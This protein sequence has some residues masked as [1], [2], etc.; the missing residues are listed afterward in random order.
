MTEFGGFG[1]LATAGPMRLGG[2]AFDML[3]ALIEA[4][5]AV[6]SKDA[7]LGRAQQGRIVDQNPQPG[8]RFR[9]DRADRN[10]RIRRGSVDAGAGS[11]P[12]CTG[13][14]RSH[15]LSAPDRRPRRALRRSRSS[16]SPAASRSGTGAS[17]NACTSA[18]IKT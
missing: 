6:V 5:L 11:R 8:T 3:T 9:G 10:K 16:T 15:W 7:L 13:K 12:L 2:R 1:I 17:T 18:D 4:S 14:K